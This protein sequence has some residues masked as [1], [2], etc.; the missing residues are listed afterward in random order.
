MSKQVTVLLTGATGFLG[1]HLLEALIGEGHNI[2][3]LKRS[4]SNP[5]RIHHLMEHVKSYD[6]D[7]Q[8]VAL[9]FDQ[10][11]IDVVMHL[12]TLYRKFDNGQGVSEMVSANVSF[13]VELLE[14]AV[15]K[16]IKGFI[17]TGTFFEYDC[18]VLPVDENAKIR[19]FNLY[20]KTKL[21]FETILETYS[22]Q[23]II[24]TFRL[25]SPFGEKDNEKLIPMIIK[26]ALANEKIELSEGHQKLDF[27]Y[28]ADIVSAYIKALDKI[29]KSTV[30]SDYQIFNLGSGI[31]LSIREIV[32]IIEEQ[33]GRNIN[34]HWGE[35]SKYEIPVVY[36]DISKVSDQL[37]WEP[38]FSIHQGIKNTIAYYK[39]KA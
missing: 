28:S 18:S 27:I 21:A 13:P 10:Q 30:N 22:D 14:T 29:V 12:S 24:N 15:R 4:T 34:K 38:S 8:P 35:D 9:A 31:A 37:N 16:G 36:A 17:N 20:S 5:W 7:Q 33:L 11:Q 1:S 19:P 6:V 26:K 39:D 3:I 2:V 23:I 25:F 32:S